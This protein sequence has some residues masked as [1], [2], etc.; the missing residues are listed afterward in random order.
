MCNLYRIVVLPAASSPSITTW[1]GTQGR[2]RKRGWQDGRHQTWQQPCEQ[3][4]QRSS[5]A[6]LAD[7]ATAS[8]NRT[9]ITTRRTTMH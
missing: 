5:N 9:T 1:D 6:A 3:Q 7:M 4:L 8:T 2:N